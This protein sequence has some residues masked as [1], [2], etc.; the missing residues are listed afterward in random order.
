MDLLH[1]FNISLIFHH[2]VAVYSVCNALF[3]NKMCIILLRRKR[4]QAYLYVLLFGSIYN[5][6]VGE[7]FPPMLNQRGGSDQQRKRALSE[8]NRQLWERS[9]GTPVI[10]F[11]S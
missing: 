4:N 5:S 7:F 11:G 2:I 3:L 1:Q 8:C 10:R 9:A 6:V